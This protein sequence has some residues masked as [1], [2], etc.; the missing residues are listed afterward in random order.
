MKIVYPAKF[1]TDEGGRIL[2]TFRDLPEAA[3]DGADMDEARS[4]AADLLDSAL[5]FRMKYREDI[6]AP[7]KPR[8]GEELVVPDAAAAMK[9]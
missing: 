3:T 5:M 2:V 1:E 7:S 4:E 8:K 6:P 9:V